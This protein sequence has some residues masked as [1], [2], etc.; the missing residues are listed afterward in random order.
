MQKMHAANAAANG[1]AGGMP[2]GM[3]MGANM[4]TGTIE[5]DDVDIADVDRR[6]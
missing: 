5:E 1:G 3:P 4:P 2:G 6:R